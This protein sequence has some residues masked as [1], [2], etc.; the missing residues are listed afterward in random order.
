M[1][2]QLRTL[3][4]VL[5]MFGGLIGFYATLW[6]FGLK[7]AIA[8][9]V[10]FVVVDGGWRLLARKPI[11][12]VWMLSN[13]LAVGFGIVDLFARTPFMLRFEAPIINVVFALIFLVGARGQRPITVK[14]AEQGGHF[15]I[16]DG[17]PDI[18]AF[19]RALTLAWAVTFFVRA[20]GFLW[21]G[22]HYPLAEAIP[23]RA[24]FGWLSIAPTLLASYQGKRT[25]A[26]CRRLGF[27]QQPVAAA[28]AS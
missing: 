27:F 3:L 2:P 24:V 23:R 20:G 10:A 11:P 13:G 4:G 5:H 7:P 14:Y 16:P 26:L 17:R 1:N 22:L 19:F 21:I 18:I 15:R 6:I 28:I 12:G 9:S 25:F 8:V